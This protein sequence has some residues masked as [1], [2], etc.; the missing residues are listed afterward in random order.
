[1]SF[2]LMLYFRTFVCE[3]GFY[4][5][6]SLKYLPFLWSP[7]LIYCQRW[8]LCWLLFDLFC[9]RCL[10]HIQP[11]STVGK[12]TAT[13]LGGSWNLTGLQAWLDSKVWACAKVAT[14]TL[15]PLL[16][17]IFPSAAWQATGAIT[18]GPLPQKTDHPYV[19]GI[20]VLRNKVKYREKNCEH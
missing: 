11:A 20:S 13:G 3:V 1:M 10:G 5:G 14:N 6:K 2:L 18:Q 4:S 17:V 7:F 15:K 9:W 12:E 19:T 8:M 16:A